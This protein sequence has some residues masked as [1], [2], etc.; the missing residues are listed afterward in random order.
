MKR[1]L[2]LQPSTLGEASIFNPESF[3]ECVRSLKLELCLMLECWILKLRSVAL[4]APLAL[5]GGCAGYHL[6]PTN[7]VA[8]R[9]RSVQVVPFVNQ[10]L[11]PRLTDAVTS[12]MHKQLQDDG[13]YQLATH[14]PGDIVVSG[15]ITDYQRTALSFAPTD[16]LT[17]KDFRLTLTA[18]VKAIERSSG[19]VLMDRKVTGFT[20]INVG[21]DLSS[22][23]RQGLPLL[24]GD[25]AKNITALLVD[26]SW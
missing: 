11:E 5:V 23:E 12:Q 24:A 6:G 13:T 17:P 4:L 15:T 1:S 7:G 21:A 19:K 3:R 16:T 9:D 22:S 8:A 20:L 26:G 10:T 25:L 14:D 2:K 18:Q